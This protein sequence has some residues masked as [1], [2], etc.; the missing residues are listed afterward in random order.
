MEETDWVGR[1]TSGTC[2][3]SS[4]GGAGTGRFSAG[5]VSPLDLVEY[6]AHLQREGGRGGTDAAPSTV[7]RALVS[8]KLPRREGLTISGRWS[9]SPGRLLMT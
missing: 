3:G 8:L 2:A 6:R 7:N 9:P 5:A 4:P 1:P